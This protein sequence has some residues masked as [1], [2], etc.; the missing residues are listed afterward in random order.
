M[1]DEFTSVQWENKPSDSEDIQQINN[2]YESQLGNN[3]NISIHNNNNL[4]TSET[5]QNNITNNNIKDHNEKPNLLL[6]NSKNTS[7]NTLN[8][9]DIDDKPDLEGSG[10]I[11]QTMILGSQEGNENEINKRKEE[12]SDDDDDDDDD[13]ETDVAVTKDNNSDINNLLTST[14][15]NSNNNECQQQ[16]QQQQNEFVNKHLHDLEGNN[17]P[18]Y[19]PEN[20]NHDDND[21]SKQSH[22]NYL[23]EINVTD[24]QTEHDGSN[25]F[26]IYH[27]KIKTDNPKFTKKNYT[28]LRR[29]SDF[30]ILYK[31]LTFDY[32]TLL[33]PPLPNKQRLEYIKG[34]RFTDEFVS[35]RCNSLNIFINRIINH[36]ILSQSDV[37]FIFL[38]DNNYWNTYKN[39]LN[40]NEAN[41]ITH[42]NSSVEGVTDF[43]MNSFKKPHVEGKYNKNFKEIDHQ[44]LKLQENLNKID[45]I[46]TK[47]VNKQ[48]SISK[49]MNAFGDEFNKLTILLNNDFNGKFREEDQIDLETKEIVNQFKT[50]S[51]NLK[52]SSDHFNELNKYIEFNYLNNLKDLEHYLISL[53]NLI[54]LKDY[55]ILDYEMLNNYLEKTIAEKENLEN[56][57][58]LTSTTE[59]TISFLSRKF[60][61]ITGLRGSSNSNI[62]NSNGTDDTISNGNTNTSSLVNERINK[63]N[64]RIV[65]LETEKNNAK[66]VYEQYEIDLLNEWTQFKKIKDNEISSSLD[67]LSNA[68]IKMYSNSFDD[69]KNFDVKSTEIEIKNK[70]DDETQKDF[71]DNNPVLK[72]HEEIKDMLQGMDI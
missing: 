47:V 20:E 45:K 42:S 29:Y 49:E 46:Y 67:Q 63:L 6:D 54:K 26:T 36:S 56:G 52:K 39:N 60:E 71:F 4:G 14:S 41:P 1:S 65:L 66:K 5:I 57:G 34:G 24:P 18:K 8:I 15:I 55:K 51:S 37:L 72:N 50:F 68:Y 53:G 7:K 16:H 23:L 32:P 31:C 38:E 27:I 12:E 58:S 13:A 40:F 64:S 19:E 11:T 48:D 30:D 62:P 9:A 10:L 43:L 21:T 61:S 44:R 35:K 70:L 33:I 3:D 28:I 59:G 25:S 17:K 2:H 69:W 22:N